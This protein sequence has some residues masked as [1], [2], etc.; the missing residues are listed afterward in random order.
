MAKSPTPKD[1]L[2]DL[3]KSLKLYRPSSYTPILVILLIIASFL[4][5]VLF[6]KVQYLEK[7]GATVTT[8]I[9]DTETEAAPTVS[10]DTI[11]GL[12]KE[13]NIVFGDVNKKNLFVEVADPSCP[14]CHIA[15]GHNPELSKQVGPNFTYQGDGGTYV[16]PVTEIKKLVDSG[17][18]GFVWIYMNGHGNG[19]LGTKAMYCAY[20]N[21][22]FWE[23]HDMLMTNEGYDLLNETVQ[24]NVENAA[25]LAQFL[26]PVYPAA[27]MQSCLESGK[28]DDKLSDD[29]S[30]A[31]SLGVSGTPG[32]FVNSTLYGG[33]YSWSDMKASLAK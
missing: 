31:Q 7:N 20:E 13:G 28:Y 17:E 15:A 23:V 1:A 18:A 9:G 21:D 24:N 12:F 26:S 10:L 19:E 6:T 16:P 3:L 32:F 30:V 2:I 29:Q 4:V 33:A 14:Y 11:K 8:N 22:K 5:G 27:D 25:Q